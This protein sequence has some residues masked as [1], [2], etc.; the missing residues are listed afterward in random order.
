[1]D[2]MIYHS[3]PNMD[4]WTRGV[5]TR[6]PQASVR[7]W[8][9]GDEA[10]A[11]YALIR[12]PP[13]A[14][15]KG[16]RGL[17]AVFSLSA[18]VDDMLA[19]LNKDPEL[20]PPGTD[21]Y[22]LEDAGMSAQM[23]EYAVH[24]VLGWYRRFD[25]YRELKR[26]KLWKPLDVPSTRE[27]PVG[28]LGAGVLGQA[29]AASLKPWG[30]PLRLWSRSPKS[31]DGAT[32]FYGRD[33]LPAFLSGLAVLISL[34]PDTPETRGLINR[35]V[36]EQLRPGAFVLNLARGSQLVE[37]DLLAALGSGQ[38]KAAALDVF[39]REPLPPEHPFWA[40]PRVAI[41]PHCAANT[42]MEETLDVVAAAINKLEAGETPPGRVDLQRGY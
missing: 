1:M 39:S 38:I 8:A 19:A 32:S 40:H 23:Q 33:Q 34:L 17:K 12:R 18:G 36:L 24:A 29:V 26:D 7:V 25:D 11:D 5:R 41:T 28:I 3:Y 22:R 6:L 21:L 35:Q 20:L 13:A 31:V 4:A 15:L 10:P 9:E 2:I 27:F 16:R 14:M 42:L 30:F 37:D